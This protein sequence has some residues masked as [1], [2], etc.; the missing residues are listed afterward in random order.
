MVVLAA[1]ATAAAD[2][3]DDILTHQ[4]QQ[5]VSLQQE[6]AP[7]SRRHAPTAGPKAPDAFCV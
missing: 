2:D 7:S 5:P 3:D 6:F 1:A 4:S